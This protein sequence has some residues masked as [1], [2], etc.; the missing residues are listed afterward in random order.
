MD[1]ENPYA[2][3][4]SKTLDS[5]GL[6]IKNQSYFQSVES[7]LYIE[8]EQMQDIEPVEIPQQLPFGVTIEAIKKQ[9]S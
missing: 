2:I 1:F 7:G 9:A 4:P 5:V 8:E 3:S 6:S